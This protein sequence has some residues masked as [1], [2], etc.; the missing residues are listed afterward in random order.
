[1]YDHV[2]LGCLQTFPSTAARSCYHVYMAVTASPPLPP[3]PLTCVYDHVE[4]RRLRCHCVEPPAQHPLPL[5]GSAQPWHWL[6][7]L[8]D[9]QQPCTAIQTMLVSPLHKYNTFVLRHWLGHLQHLQQQH[10]SFSASLLVF[11]AA[12]VCSKVRSPG[13]GHLQHLQQPRYGHRHSVKVAAVSTSRCV[14]RVLAVLKAVRSP[15][16]GQ[17][18][19]STP[20]AATQTRVCRRHRLC[21]SDATNRFTHTARWAPATT[22]ALQ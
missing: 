16:T 18:P 8:Q 10:R 12:L 21:S 14:L 1:V 3:L 19:S 5:E 4:L 20:A 9:L 7:H 13:T 11:R 22:Q 17:W 6:C 15:G 2:E